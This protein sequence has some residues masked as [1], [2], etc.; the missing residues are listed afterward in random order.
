M[1]ALKK[2]VFVPNKGTHDYTK[3]WDFGDLVFC[4][5]G[6]ISRT[7]L[8]TMQAEMATA[9]NDA[10]E[11]D[12]ILLTSL[13][14]LCAVACGMFSAKFGRLN[15]LLYERGQYVER[16]LDFDTVEAGQ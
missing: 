15:I 4:T 8:A 9:M 11:D 2:K 10:D 14:S 1:S 5:T 7:D 13:A 12:Y 3:A 6:E 16:H